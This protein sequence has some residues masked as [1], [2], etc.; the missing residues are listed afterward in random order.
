MNPVTTKLEELTPEADKQREKAVSPG[1]PYKIGVQ[2]AADLA[3]V[4]LDD[5]QV[6]AAASAVPYTVGIAGGT[7]PGR[8]S[9]LRIVCGKIKI[10]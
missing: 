3:G 1:S 8:Y 4:K 6:D 7:V 10:W 5:K 9:L 2:K